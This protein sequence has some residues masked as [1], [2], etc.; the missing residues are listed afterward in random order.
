[1][2][3]R[4]KLITRV[5]E[6]I[7]PLHD[8]VVAIK[9]IEGGYYQRA[10]EKVEEG[11]RVLEVGCGSG[12]LLQTICEK[13]YGVGLDISE[14][15]IKMAKERLRNCPYDFVLGTATNLPFRSNSFDYAV[16]F[17]MAHHLTDE[18]KIE[19]IEEIL[20]VAREY[21]FGEVGKTL[22][23]SSVLL[24]LIG[25]KGLLRREHFKEAG[26]EL[27]EWED[28]GGFCLVKGRARK[29]T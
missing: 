15:L 25:R 14:K 24:K 8:D 17:T 9:F 19:M 13:T 2:P 20:R 1:M 16:T 27:L 21:L 6:A 28:M 26:A 7:Y 11:S 22:C 12:R 4:P 10:L 5:L 29:H 23:W 18:E 3:A